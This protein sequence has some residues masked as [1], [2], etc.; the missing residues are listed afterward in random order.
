M[1]LYYSER[2]KEYEKVY[3]R[4][5]V[6]RQQEQLKIQATMKQ[7]FANKDVLEVACGTGYWT[8]FV[9]QTASH[10]TA[11][12]FSEEVLDIAKEKNIN[13][14]KAIFHQGDAYQLDK[15]PGR[16]N[17]AYANFWLSHI[18]KTRIQEFLKQL[19]TRLGSGSP[20]FLADNMYNESVG[21][22]LV[23][24]LNDENTYKVRT[25]DGG[26]QYEI[27]KNYFSKTELRELFEPYSCDLEVHIGRCFWWVYYRAK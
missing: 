20:V 21:G 9:V 12:D 19:H 6:V 23:Q 26:S 11:I 25:L 5:D 2:A 13:S 7:L 3:F 22:T 4:D 10:I 17:A 16:F 1:K 27:L 18:P 14:N 15:V 8:Q 24:K